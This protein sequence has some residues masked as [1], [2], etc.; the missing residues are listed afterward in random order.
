MQCFWNLLN[1]SVLQDHNKLKN[2]LNQNLIKEEIS[3]KL[4]KPKNPDVQ[5]LLPNLNGYLL[6]FKDLK[7]I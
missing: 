5:A 7:A 3:S 6:D 4:I 2:S 1:C